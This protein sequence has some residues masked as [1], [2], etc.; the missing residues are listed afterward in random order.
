MVWLGLER[1]FSTS[2][3]SNMSSEML[4]SLSVSI[5]ALLVDLILFTTEN[6]H[7]TEQLVTGSVIRIRSTVHVGKNIF[8]T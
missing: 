8:V 3:F 1:S 5:V 2:S 4:F 7:S 6:R